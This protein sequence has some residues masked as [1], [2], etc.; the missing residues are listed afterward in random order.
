[1]DWLYNDVDEYS[2]KGLS[3][4]LKYSITASNLSITPNMKTSKK[5]E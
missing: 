1:M 3:H 4:N 2:P 5:M